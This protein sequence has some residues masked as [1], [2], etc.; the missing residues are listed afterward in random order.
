MSS[1]NPLTLCT[2]VDIYIYI[3]TNIYIYIYT[4]IYIYLY[5]YIYIYV[6]TY[7]CETTETCGWRKNENLPTIKLVY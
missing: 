7:I 4:N 3:Y 6:Y 5:I 2:T 1:F